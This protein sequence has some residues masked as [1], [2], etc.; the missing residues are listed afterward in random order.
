MPC[1]LMDKKSWSFVAHH[2]HAPTPEIKNTMSQLVE[3][4]TVA[5]RFGQI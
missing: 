2:T 4:I 5:H 1:V 3:I